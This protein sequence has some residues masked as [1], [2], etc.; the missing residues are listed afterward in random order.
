MQKLAKK[1]L[2]IVII[3]TAL[4]NI[5]NNQCVDNTVRCI[6]CL[7][8]TSCKTCDLDFPLNSGVCY[9]SFQGPGIGLNSNSICVYCFDT[10]CN[11]CYNYLVCT[12]CMNYYGVV[13]GS[14]YQC[15]DINCMIGN[16]KQFIII[17]I[18][19]INIIFLYS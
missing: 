17:S 6:V 13:G 9:C 2:L 1:Q 18:Y 10:S 12:K 11:I 16:G 7:D 8:S 5:V 4:Q 14:C 19:I 15:A 3:Y